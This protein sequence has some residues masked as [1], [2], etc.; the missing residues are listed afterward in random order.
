MNKLRIILLINKIVVK[1]WPENCVE[2]RERGVA[3]QD[4]ALGPV[5]AKLPVI[6]SSFV[7]MVNQFCQSL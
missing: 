1:I 5:E 6:A 3:N 2:D 7:L 4:L